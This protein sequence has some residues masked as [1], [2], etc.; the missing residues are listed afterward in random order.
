MRLPRP[1]VPLAIRA[2]V[3]RRQVDEKW[4]PP[5]SVDVVLPDTA[6]A[7]H[8]LY[9]WLCLLFPD[10]PCQLDHDPPLAARKKIRD[11]NGAVIGYSPA[12][13]DPDFL[14]YRAKEDHRVKTY[15]RGE[16]GQYSDTVLIKRER[17]RDKKKAGKLRKYRWPK[18]KLKS[19][20]FHAA[21]P[22]GHGE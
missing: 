8:K 12:A 2:K 9:H 15:V 21:I 19:R 17:K 5:G 3:A 22:S 7:S 20:S 6:R 10:E 1:F 14:V 4:P 11:K 16:H 18:R 13:N